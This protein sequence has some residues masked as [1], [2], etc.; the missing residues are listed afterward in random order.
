MLCVIGRRQ[1]LQLWEKVLHAKVGLR[2]VAVAT[3]EGA[4]WERLSLRGRGRR[5]GSCLSSFRDTACCSRR[6]A[7][8]HA[9]SESMTHSQHRT[10]VDSCMLWDAAEA[11]WDVHRAVVVVVGC[12]SDMVELLSGRLGCRCV[13]NESVVRFVLHHRRLDRRRQIHIDGSGWSCLTRSCATSV[14]GSFFDTPSVLLLL[15]F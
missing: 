2:A 13:W 7:H 12:D 11:T 10:V 14:D 5:D 4:G 15:C 3:R 1:V 9:P 6:G 8:R